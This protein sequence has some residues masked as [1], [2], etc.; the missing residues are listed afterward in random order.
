MNKNTWCLVNQT[1]II[2]FHIM[3]LFSITL[4]QTHVR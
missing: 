3:L 2:T 4:A 1:R